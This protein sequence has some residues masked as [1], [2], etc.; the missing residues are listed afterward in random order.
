MAGSNRREQI[1]EAAGEVLAARGIGGLSV[2]AVAAQAGVGASTL[3]H[4]F[5]TQQDLHDAVLGQALDAQLTDRR[6]HDATVP[7][8][9]R[10]AECLL[11]FLPDSDAQIPHLHGWFGMYAAALAPGHT[12]TGVSVLHALTA[13]G[14]RRV[15]QWV[16]DS[17]EGTSTSIPDPAGTALRLLILVDGISLQLLTPGTPLTLDVARQML[18]EAAATAVG[19]ARR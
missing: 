6:I 2:R 12:E 19:D 18:R 5:P 16:R 13:G 14:R 15:E 4:Y 17:V 10:L 7:S 1:V 3:R 11:Q 9:E 8:D